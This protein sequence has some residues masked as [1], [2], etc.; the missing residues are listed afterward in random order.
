MEAAGHCAC[1]GADLG[2]GALQGS[3]ITREPGAGHSRHQ[4]LCPEGGQRMNPSLCCS[5]VQKLCKKKK[6]RHAGVP[7]S[8]QE[9]H[10][11]RIPSTARNP[12]I[13][14]KCRKA[15][16]V[17]GR[18]GTHVAHPHARG[19]LRPVHPSG[20]APGIFPVS[21]FEEMGNVR[22]PGFER[23][24]LWRAPGFCCGCCAAVLPQDLWACGNETW[25]KN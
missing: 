3:E 8:S 24:A 11:E 13:T 9:N 25:G 1:P 12:K 19:H 23:A 5:I 22:A 21:A 10:H 7:A 4:T 17:P 2:P 16:Q 15:A 6:P 20:E 14:L 18:T